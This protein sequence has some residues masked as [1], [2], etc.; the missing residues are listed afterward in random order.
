MSIDDASRTLLV[1][2]GHVRTTLYASSLS[3]AHVAQL[4]G[5]DAGTVEH[6]PSRTTLPEPLT[7][8]DLGPQ[9]F[10][11]LANKHAVPAVCR[12]PRH[13]TMTDYDDYGMPVGAYSEPEKLTHQAWRVARA[14]FIFRVRPEV[15]KRWDSVRR[16]GWNWR[17]WISMVKV[18]CVVW[19]VVVYR[20][21]RS[22]I[23]NSVDDCRWEKWE[24]WVGFTG[25][26]GA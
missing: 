12:A 13:R 18:L 25:L 7:P 16:G 21:E 8:R 6:T 15:E 10:L 3:S 14:F 19:L 26:L 22:A 20:G 4:P 11:S 1:V 24:N 5:P 2:V 9:S 17:I 23:R